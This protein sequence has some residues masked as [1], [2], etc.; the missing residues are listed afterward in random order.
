MYQPHG[1]DHDHDHDL[2][3]GLGEDEEHQDQQARLLQPH[4]QQPA[5]VVSSRL[6][7]HVNASGR[8]V[9]SISL[10]QAQDTP[11]TTASGSSGAPDARSTI[12]ATTAMRQRTSSVPSVLP[13]VDA[14]RTQAVAGLVSKHKH[15]QSAGQVAPPA[16]NA[17]GVSARLSSP[18]D[19]RKKG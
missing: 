11:A 3:H 15:T 13:L 19:A 6:T 18:A 14:T 7:V 17:H 1:P 5:K 9:R 12:T 8:G 10:R 4:A 2:N 16:T